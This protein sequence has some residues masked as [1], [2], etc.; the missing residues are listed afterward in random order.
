MKRILREPP[1]ILSTR[2]VPVHTQKGEFFI[3]CKVDTNR[4]NYLHKRENTV[5]SGEGFQMY[6]NSNSRSFL[7]VLKDLNFSFAIRHNTT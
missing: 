3:L 6:L 1:S 4:W 2:D 5:Q 7:S